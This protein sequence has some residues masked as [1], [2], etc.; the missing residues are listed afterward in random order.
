MVISEWWKEKHLEGNG[1][2]LIP[3]KKLNLNDLNLCWDLNPGRPEYEGVLTTDHNV[4]WLVIGQPD[5]VFMVFSVCLSYS[6]NLFALWRICLCL[7]VRISL[8]FH[9]DHNV[10]LKRKSEEIELELHRTVTA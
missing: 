5:K 9:K 1:S 4:Q 6:W 3:Q 2:C 10:C 8:N 7:K